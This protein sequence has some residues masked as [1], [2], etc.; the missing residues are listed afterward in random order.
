MSTRDPLP[1]AG[2]LPAAAL[3][4]LAALAPPG[5]ARI[6]TRAARG[7]VPDGV[8][9]YPPRVLLL[10]DAAAGSGKGRSSLVVVPDL[11][12]GYDIRPVTFLARN[13]L[14]VDVEDGMLKSL[15]SGIDTTP[16][17]TFFKGA[18]EAGAKMA[19]ALGVSAREIDGSFG[20][21]T[22]I[23]ALRPDGTFT[24][25]PRPAAAAT[26]GAGAPPPASRGSGAPRK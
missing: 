17:L 13:D 5:C 25:V 4:I 16:A 26:A 6:E 12:A 7:K 2:L 8:R 14:R 24:P 18:G 11:G 22:G 9:V 1:A 15:S 19:A 23:Y 10:V 3:I 20:L 21:P